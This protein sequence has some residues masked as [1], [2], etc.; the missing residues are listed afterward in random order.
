MNYL[1]YVIRYAVIYIIRALIPVPYTYKGITDISLADLATI[2]HRILF[3]PIKLRT[4]EKEGGSGKDE[5]VGYWSRTEVTDV[6][7]KPLS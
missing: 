1:T 2:S 5:H 6:L 7:S 3:E 4:K